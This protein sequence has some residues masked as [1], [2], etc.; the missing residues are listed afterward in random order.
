MFD[1][2][3]VA[4]ASDEWLKPARYKEASKF[5]EENGYDEEGEVIEEFADEIKEFINN[6]KEWD[7]E[8]FEIFDQNF[9]WSDID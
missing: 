4:L 2:L 5:F 3:N 1:V 7:Y 9:D 6:L 8:E